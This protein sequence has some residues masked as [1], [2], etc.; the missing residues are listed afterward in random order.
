VVTPSK[1]DLSIVIPSYNSERTIVDCLESLKR[2]KTQKS[3]EVIVVNSSNDHTVDLIRDKFPSVT[4]LSFS[5]RK[6]P[7]DARNIGI[8]HS[9]A[10]IIAFMDSDCTVDENWVDQV[11]GAHEGNHDVV[12]GVILN[13]AS[14]NLTGWAYYFCEF[15]LWLPNDKIREIPEIAGCCLSIKRRTFDEYGPFVE[16]TYCSDTAL[17]WKMRWDGI[18]V[19]CVPS[20]KVYHTAHYTFRSLLSHIF[21]HRRQ[22]ARLMVREKKLSSLQKSVFCLLSPLLSPVLFLVVFL[23]VLKSGA[24]LTEFFCSSLLVFAGLTA[25]AWGEF[26]G[27]VET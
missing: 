15:N 13:G 4:V 5:Q 7:G 18:K 8:S 14:K 12:G 25:R 26:T 10:P 20:I 21:S 27:F 22:F 23:R 9:R 3:F 17:H 2:Q 19:L 16:D 1:P 24:F 11:T 6:F